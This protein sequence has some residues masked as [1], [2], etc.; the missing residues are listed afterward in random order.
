MI[1][2]AMTSRKFSA[3]TYVDLAKARAKIERDIAP[4]ECARLLAQSLALTAVKADLGFYWDDQGRINVA[5]SALATMKLTC[6]ACSQPLALDIEA[7]IVGILVRSE[8]EAQTLKND[9]D[10]LKVVVVTGPELNEVELVE[11]ELLLRLPSQV[12]VDANCERRPNMS[13]GPSLAVEPV[14]EKPANTHRP[15]ADLA[16]LVLS[17][18]TT[19]PKSKEEK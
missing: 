12:C 3:P 18:E 16:K 9:A 14:D 10:E 19:T 17:A 15:F 7:E 11:D 1:A 4:E 6:Q 2:A 5:G 13:F 8:L